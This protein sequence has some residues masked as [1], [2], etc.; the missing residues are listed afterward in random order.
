MVCI[1]SQLTFCSPGNILRRTAVETD[2][3]NVVSRIFSLDESSVESAHTLFY[4]GI[5]SAEMVSMKQHVWSEKIAELTAD[6]CYIDA[7]ENKFSEKIINLADPIILDFGDLTLNEINR[8]LAEIAQQ[9]SSIPVFDVIAGCVFYPA[10]LLGYEAQLTQGRQ[11]KLLL[12]EST[13]LVNK[14]LT[15]S[16]KIQEF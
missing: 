8:K 6:Y 16:T 14:T 1:G 11:T 2:E 10:L 12:W 4:D 9:C 3:R 13:D 15:V 5:V 7:S